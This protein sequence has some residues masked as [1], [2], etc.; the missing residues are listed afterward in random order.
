MDF[1]LSLSECLSPSPRTTVRAAA[2]SLHN[3]K[4]YSWAGDLL[5][6]FGS[7]TAAAF[8]LGLGVGLGL[9]LGLTK[10]NLLLGA[11]G[12][13]ELLVPRASCRSPARTL[14]IY[15]ILPWLCL[16]VRLAFPRFPSSRT[17]WCP[18]SLLGV[19]CWKLKI[20]IASTFCPQKTFP[21]CLEKVE[22]LSD[23][24]PLRSGPFPRK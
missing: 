19:D 5:P 12:R 3:D 11:T 23:F 18:F 6:L 2:G 4:C 16:P 13:Q 8:R 22:I 7:R 10:L 24:L 20:I 9:G 14:S 15:H 21:R 17:L 1:C